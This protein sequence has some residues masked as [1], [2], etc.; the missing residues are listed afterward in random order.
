MKILLTGAT[1]FVGKRLIKE[2]IHEGHELYLLVRSEYKYNSLLKNFT[3]SDAQKINAIYGDIT[4][5]NL[6]IDEEKRNELKNKL[7]AVY[8]MAA[9]LSFDPERREETFK[10]NVEGTRHVLD[11]SKA[12]QIKKFIYVSTAYTLGK[13]N[14]AKE[15]LHDINH[16]FVNPYEE[17]K[18]VSEHLV[19]DYKEDFEVVIMRPAIIIGDSK[20]GEADTTFALYGI[21]RGLKLLKRRIMK[22][23]DWQQRLY[24]LII[25]RDTASNIVPV[26]YVAKVLKIALK[27][28][29]KNKIYHITN[30][31]PPSHEA[32][33]EIIKDVLK[34]PNISLTPDAKPESL[35]DLEAFLNDPLKVFHDYWN[36]T[37]SFASTNTKMLLEKVGESELELNKQSLRKI[38]QQFV[39]DK[40]AVN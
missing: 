17:S 10:V 34:F 1:G 36:R 31:N 20:T 40:I 2:L 6:G 33:F 14:F 7:D 38:I 39:D 15:E 5:L 26:D 9:L 13:K 27:H 8:H 30:P 32:V 11:F 4:L 35:T 25:E 28:G 24:R 23:Q 3:K 16:K 22:Q 29:E 19:F 18:C 12:I 37:I 21:L